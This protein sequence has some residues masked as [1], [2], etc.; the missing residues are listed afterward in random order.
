M[1]PQLLSFLYVSRSKQQS[2]HQCYILAVRDV[3]DSVLVRGDCCS[4]ARPRASCS[5]LL[6]EGILK[7]N[8]CLSQFPVNRA[9]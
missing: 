3:T 2:T 4:S 9:F 6:I 1:K 5:V 8:G 7:S